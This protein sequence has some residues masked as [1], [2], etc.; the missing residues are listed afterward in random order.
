VSVNSIATNVAYARKLLGL[1][2]EERGVRS[3]RAAFAQRSR[4]MHPDTAM[5]IGGALSG[6]RISFADLK[7]ARD[8]LLQE[9]EK[10]ER[11]C[12]LCGGVGKVHASM[13]W[14]SCSACKGTGDKRP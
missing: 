13:G 7:S 14:R 5:Q 6:A 1:L 11:A 10:S 12:K 2:P 3:I 8:C 9:A 4:E